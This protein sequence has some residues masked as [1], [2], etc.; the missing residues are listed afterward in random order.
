MYTKTLG[1]SARLVKIMLAL[2]DGKL[3]VWLE[4]DMGGRH[5]KR[6]TLLLDHPAAIFYAKPTLVRKSTMCLDAGLN[7]IFWLLGKQYAP[8][9]FVRKGS[10]SS[11][12]PSHH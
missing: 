5:L 7:M 2:P 12:G 8:D 1:E 3:R 9:F 10:M 11:R 6:F 4:F